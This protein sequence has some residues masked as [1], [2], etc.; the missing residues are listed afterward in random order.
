[1]SR[2]VLL[3]GATDGIGLALASRY[4]HEGWDLAVIGRSRAKMDRVTR[5]LRREYVGATVTGVLCDV[6]DEL[7]VP[8]AFD[9]AVDELGGLDLLVYCAGTRSHGETAEEKYAA[10]ARML[11]VNLSGSIQFVELAAEYLSAAGDGHIAA[12]GSVA[13][14]WPRP[15]DPS[16]SASKAGLHAYLEGLRMRLRDS[17]VRVTTIKP[18]SVRTRMLSGNPVGAI[19]PGDA[20][21]R[22]QRGLSEG[23][24]VLYVP[25]WWRLV[26]LGLRLSPRWL[27]RRLISY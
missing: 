4:L 20:A 27:L 7:R 23:R 26:S 25:R 5:T 19:D 9:Q 10:A 3:V 14:D 2:R 6:T 13:G 12:I 18:G 24:D 21:R 1:M 11:D 22:I 17:G 15:R 16:Y 8:D